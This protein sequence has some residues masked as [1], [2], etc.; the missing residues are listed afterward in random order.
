MWPASFQRALP[1]IPVPILK[2]DADLSL[3]L[4]PL[5]DTVYEV[6]RYG[7]TIDYSKP[8]TPPLTVEEQTW[9]ENRIREWRKSNMMAQTGAASPFSTGRKSAARRRRR[10]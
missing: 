10:K 1:V 9:V 6:S 3:D 8:L 2:P 4:Q 5:I 7:R